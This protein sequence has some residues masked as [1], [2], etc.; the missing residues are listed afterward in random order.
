MGLKLSR[1]INEG[2]IFENKQKKIFEGKK[3]IVLFLQCTTTLNVNFHS[4]EVRVPYTAFVFFYVYV[5]FSESR[6][7]RMTI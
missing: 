5:C 2:L 6:I 1:I 7:Y 3:Y 4:C